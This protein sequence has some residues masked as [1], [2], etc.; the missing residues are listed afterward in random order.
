MT[1]CLNP[2]WLQV[3]GSSMHHAV[4]VRLLDDNLVHQMLV[5]LPISGTHY[6]INQ[7]SDTGHEAR[8]KFLFY[9]YCDMVSL[10]GP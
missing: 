1:F 9:C 4:I 10:T 3:S 5:L 2:H 6:S 7:H 8:K